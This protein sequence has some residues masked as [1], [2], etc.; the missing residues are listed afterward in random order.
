VANKHERLINWQP[1]AEKT[2]NNKIMYLRWE[3]GLCSQKWPILE[4]RSQLIKGPTE[5]NS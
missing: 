4:I 5:V 3:V 2:N 1:Q